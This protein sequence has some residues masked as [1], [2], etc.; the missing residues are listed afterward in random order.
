MDTL[1][2]IY[3]T[4]RIEQLITI[5]IIITE[6]CQASSVFMA[7]DLIIAANFSARKYFNSAKRLFNY[8]LIGLTAS[9]K[10]YNGNQ[11]TGL[12]TIEEC[13]R[14]DVVILPGAFEAVLSH[15]QAGVLLAD[16]SELISIV[17]L[18]HKAG[19]TI[20]AVC[21]GNFI[22]ASANIS[23][24]RPLTCHWASQQAA[25]LLF[26]EQL[27]DSDKLLIDHGDIISAGGA[28]A[29]SQL[30]F[31]II[32]RFHSR[33]L[34]LATG[35]LMMIEVNFEQQSRFSIFRP[36]QDHGDTIVEKL[37]RKIENSFSEDIDTTKFSDQE[38]IGL[39]QLTR[40]FKK[41]TGETPLSYL[42]RYRVEQVK[43][44]LE[45][46]ETATNDLILQVGYEDPASF[47][48]LFKR[49]TGITMQAYRN[50]FSAI[51]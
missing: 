47:R 27:F 26:P 22:L 10:A 3:I 36:K 35:K 1:Q 25:N 23:S 15:Q 31:Y 5:G 34:A 21:T 43:I 38:G 2:A 41:A 50:R 24:Q 19:S 40:R 28:A 8:Q 37:Q 11:I 42:Q 48:R 45:S 18:W 30:I 6:R 32:I 29:I 51:R 49:L 33:E 44:R 7:V 14:P 4:T 17:A 46:T 9:A 39:R 13:A 12:T 20:T 16:M